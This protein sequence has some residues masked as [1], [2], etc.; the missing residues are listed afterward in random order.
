MPRNNYFSESP[1][2]S[3]DEH[4]NNIQDSID[5]LETDNETDID[6][7]NSSEI[8]PSL[9]SNKT[10]SLPKKRKRRKLKAEV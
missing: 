2:I 9:K 6:D 10:T 4:I 1:L 3:S 7:N 5:D 8:G